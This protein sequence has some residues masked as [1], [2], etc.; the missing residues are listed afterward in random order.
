MT[1]SPIPIL[2]DVGEVVAVS[3]PEGLASIRERR[4]G[5]PFLQGVLS[6][7][8]GCRLFVV[9][10]LDKDVSGVI[11][12]ART[13]EAHRDLSLQ[14][15]NREV[16][17]TYV[18]LVFGTVTPDEGAID[19][20]LRAFGSGRIAVDRLRGKPCR[21]EFRV[22]DRRAGWTVVEV[23]PRTGR[24][25]QIRA[26][27]Y[28]MGHPVA[29]D[30]LYGDQRSRAG[31]SRLMLHAESIAFR[32]LDRRAITVRAPWPESFGR[33]IETVLPAAGESIQAGR[34]RQR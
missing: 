20:P 31:M 17:K 25:H 12:F 21:T 26:H 3:K 23:K 27:F 6:E 32:L 10:R 15:E 16:E 33:V 22:L 30:P 13:P 19:S 7:Q 24:R 29:G 34:L 9:H 4:E 14:F 2:F 18:A 5:S 1:V 11:L 8:L 28:S